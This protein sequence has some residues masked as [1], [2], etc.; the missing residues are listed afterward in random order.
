MATVRQLADLFDGFWNAAH[1]FDASYNGVLGFDHL[2]PD[3]S[4]ECQA[5]WRAQLDAMLA[6]ARSRQ[7]MGQ[8][9]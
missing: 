9:P 3:L 5:A 2:V 1:P 8:P 4:E 7:S 6:D